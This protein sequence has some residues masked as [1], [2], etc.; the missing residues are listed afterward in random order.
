MLFDYAD[1]TN[2]FMQYLSRV[3]DIFETPYVYVI[4]DLNASNHQ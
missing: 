3:N 2:D 4:G 1:N